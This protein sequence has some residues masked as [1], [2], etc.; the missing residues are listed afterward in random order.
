ML[1]WLYGLFRR[2]PDR[3]IFRYRDGTRRRTADPVEV[4]SALAAMLGDDWRERVKNYGAPAPLGLAGLQL[5]E[6]KSRKGDERKAI[7]AA[8]DAAFGVSPYTDDAG[9]S[10]PRGLTGAERFGLLEGFNRFCLDLMVLARPFL[11]PPPRGSPGP[12]PPPP[13]S[14]PAPTLAGDGSPPAGPT[15]PPEPSS[16]ESAA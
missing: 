13:P 11:R 2:T 3:F 5:E 4:E 10:R 12:E 9:T 6:W 14:G 15:T 8:V 1:G 16:L 7:L